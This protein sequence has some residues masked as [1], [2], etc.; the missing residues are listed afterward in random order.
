ML[1]NYTNDLVFS[2]ERLSTSPFAV[3]RLNASADLPFP[4][5]AS[6]PTNLTGLDMDTL[7]QQ[8]RLFYVD[9]RSQQVL[10]KLDGRYS[11][12]CDAY[13][14]ID[15][16]TSDFLP[17]AIRANTTS[18][19]VYS[20]L[21]QADDWL[22]AKMMFNSADLWGSQFYHLTNTHDLGEIILESAIRTLSDNHPVMGIMNRR[23]SFFLSALKW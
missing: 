23:R 22:L 16:K 4:V 20:P 19:V 2:M 21:D 10:P 11:A 9:W 14:Y 3:V 12:V 6:I 8:G 13:F 5:D 15:P 1:Q 17:L 7:H 18:E